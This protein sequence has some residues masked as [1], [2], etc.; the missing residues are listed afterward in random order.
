MFTV[1]SRRQR[2]VLEVQIITGELTLCFMVRA[3]ITIWQ[4]FSPVAIS[5]IYYT[6]ALYFTLLEVYNL[7]F[8]Y[9]C[10]NNNN[11]IT[12]IVFIIVI[13]LIL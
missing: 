2:I 3:G 11:H 9:C 6:D 7:L 13:A 8:N 5:G 10:L 12:I 4:I 1:Q